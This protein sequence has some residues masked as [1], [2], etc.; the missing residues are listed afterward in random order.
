MPIEKHR[1]QV[2]NNFRNDNAETDVDTGACI[3]Y[4]SDD[5]K[6]YCV[7]STPQ[8]STAPSPF[9]SRLHF[10]SSSPQLLKHYSLSLLHTT[11]Q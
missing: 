7:R 1:M 6:K 3:I 8:L 11:K 2:I 5:P 10:M 9:V 4:V